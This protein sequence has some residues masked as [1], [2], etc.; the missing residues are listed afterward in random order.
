MNTYS[1]YMHITPN[2]KRYIGITAKEPKK[3]WCGGSGYYYNRRFHEAIKKYGWD[4]IKHKVL[5]TGLS[6]EEAEQKEIELIAKY[7]TT[8][9]K[10]GFNYTNGGNHVGMVSEETK[11]ILSNKARKT[12]CI[13]IETGQVFPSIREAARQINVSPSS[14]SNSCSS[15]GKLSCKGYHFVYENIEKR[16]KVQNKQVKYVKWW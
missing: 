11:K 10:R 1:V 16:N 6:K 3:R 5:Y 2:N 7:N 8:D 4:N 9:P 14:I 12:K 15:N 13:C